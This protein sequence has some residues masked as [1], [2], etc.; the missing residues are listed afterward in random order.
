MKRIRGRAGGLPPAGLDQ[1]LSCKKNE[2]EA[3]AS[4]PSRPVTPVTSSDC[5]L[6]AVYHVHFGSLPVLSR[7]DGHNFSTTHF[8]HSGLRA[9]QICLPW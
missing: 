6:E 8:S 3:G 1:A 7:D 4:P 5:K 2:E 9:L